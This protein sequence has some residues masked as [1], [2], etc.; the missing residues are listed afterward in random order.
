MGPFGSFVPPLGLRVFCYLLSE[1]IISPSAFPLV[2]IAHNL[3]YYFAPR[4]SPVHIARNLTSYALSVSNQ[5]FVRHSKMDAGHTQ[6]PTFSSAELFDPDLP[7]VKTG[8]A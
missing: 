8:Q 7:L 1:F 4:F 2:N 5:T 6:T 3:M